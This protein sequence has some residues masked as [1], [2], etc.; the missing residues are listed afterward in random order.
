MRILISGGA[1]F[2]GSHAADF[3]RHDGHSVLVLDNFSTGSM[4]NIEHFLAKGGHYSQADVRLHKGDVAILQTVD[5]VFRDFKPETVVHLAAQPAIST[6]LENPVLDLETNGIGTLNML[7]AARKFGVKRFIFSSTSAVYRESRYFKTR[8]DTPLEPT[9]PYGISK[10]AAETYVRLMFPG[11]VILRF[12][13]VYGP[14]QVPLGENQLIPRIIRHFLHGD[15]FFINGDGNQKRDF[16]YVSDV[17]YAI[18]CSLF[19]VPGTYNIASGKG[20]SVNKVSRIMETYFGV[21]GYK[22]DH[23]G[24]NDPRRYVCQEVIAARKGLGYTPKVNIFDGIG[25]TID[26]W[27]RQK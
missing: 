23:T 8:E 11:A 16:V 18:S 10:L 3:M 24:T 4:K 25:R 15:K 1:G 13:N 17:V 19:G 2:I 20:T 26:W 21:E 6:S 14:R 9:S 7:L 12:G 5:E 27:K 22:W